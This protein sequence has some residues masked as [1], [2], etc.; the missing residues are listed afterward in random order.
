MKLTSLPIS[1]LSDFVEAVNNLEVN[2]ILEVCYECSKLTSNEVFKIFEE[3]KYIIY[4]GLYGDLVTLFDSWTKVKDVRSYRHVFLGNI[5][6]KGPKQLETLLAIFSLKARMKEEVQIIV[7]VEEIYGIDFPEHLISRFGPKG[8][9]IYKCFRE[10][11][12]RMLFAVM[13]RREFLL[14]HSAPPLTNVNRGCRMHDCYSWSNLKERQML[15]EEIMWSKPSNVCSWDDDPSE[16]IVPTPE[17]R[18]FLWGPGMTKRILKTFGVK[19]IV[20]DHDPVDGIEKVHRG[21]VLTISTSKVP[22]LGTRKAA[23]LLLDTMEKRKEVI[24]L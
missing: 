1:S 3:G 13:I 2:D 7:G 9:E 5:V 17:L 11:F 19:G 15:I 20:R 10:V 24:Y 18:G 16:C 12:E 21:K 8:K 22:T 23:I 6:G 4:G 14:V